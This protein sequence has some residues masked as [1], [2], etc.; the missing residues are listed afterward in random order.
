MVGCGGGGGGG[1]DT[2]PATP[3]DPG[4]TTAS[5]TS[6][7]FTW[8]DTSSNET[9][10]EVQRAAAG[11]WATVGDTARNVATYTDT[12]LT[13]GVLYSYR[14]R[15]LG[16]STNSGWTTAVDIAPG[17]VA[18]TAPSNLR[19]SDITASS[20]ILSWD[21]NSSTETSFELQRQS[22]GGAWATLTSPA[23]NATS[24]TDNSVEGNTTYN[25]RVRAVRYG[26]GSTY[27]GPLAV[28]TLNPGAVGAVIGTVSSFA[29]GAA[30]SGASVTV[31]ARSTTSRADGTFTVTSVVAGSQTITVS[32]SGYTRFTG[33]VTVIASGTVSVGDV[34]LV[35]SGDGPPPPPF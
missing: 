33:T 24:Y 20:V 21:D 23:A 11:V 13:S 12:G 9:G 17:T 28:T 7:T 4:V 15:A 8:T 30:L 29:T 14:V 2:T 26:V 1:E 18:P 6:V 25:Y 10:F 3:T 22:S 35:V 27:A 5:N 31:G 34:G 32:A 16:A 19:S